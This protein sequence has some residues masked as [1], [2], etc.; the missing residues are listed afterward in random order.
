MGILRTYIMN[1]LNYSTHCV[2]VACALSTLNYSTHWVNSNISHLCEY[3]PEGQ[4]TTLITEYWNL[5]ERYKLRKETFTS[6]RNKK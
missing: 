2:D 1:T 6:C 4:K 3:P 5:L